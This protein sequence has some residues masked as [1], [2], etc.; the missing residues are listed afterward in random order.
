MRLLSLDT[1]DPTLR[2]LLVCLP[3]MRSLPV[4]M[5]KET[6]VSILQAGYS[7]EYSFGIFNYL[8]ESNVAIL[9]AFIEEVTR[10]D[11]K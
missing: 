11:W 3:T 4:N 2:T 8:M 1:I 7:Y 5:E 6:F 10:Y 9:V